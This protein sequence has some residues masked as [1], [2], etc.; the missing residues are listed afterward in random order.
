MKGHII[1]PHRKPTKKNK[2]KLIENS[3]FHRFRICLTVNYNKIAN[4]FL[5]PESPHFRA[6]VETKSLEK[7]FGSSIQRAEM[8]GKLAKL[9]DVRL[10]LIV[11]TVILSRSRYKEQELKLQDVGSGFSSSL[12][13]RRSRRSF[14]GHVRLGLSKRMSNSL[15]RKISGR[16]R[17]SHLSDGETLSDY[18]LKP[19]GSVRVCS[20]TLT[21]DN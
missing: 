14:S 1:L 8:L 20:T 6:K 10:Q 17:V 5:D 15:D 3:S 11:S 21:V 13:E 4:D 2:D 16:N 19:V 7:K 12:T 9:E 18:I